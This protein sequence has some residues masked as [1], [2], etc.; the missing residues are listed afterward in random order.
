MVTVQ[1]QKHMF[2]ILPS[3]ARYYIYMFA[4]FALLSLMMIMVN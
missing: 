2:F 4:R 3:I 1:D